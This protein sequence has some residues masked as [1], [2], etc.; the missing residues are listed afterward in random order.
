VDP[1]A[2]STLRPAAVCR[3]LLAAMEAA[4]G[5]RRSRKRDQ[6]PDALGLDVK[7][8]LLAAVVAAD[9]EPADLERWLVERTARPAAGEDAGALAAMARTVLDEWRLAHRMPAFAQW[10]DAGAPSEDAG[11]GHDRPR[12][13]LKTARLG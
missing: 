9:P 4:E 8:R 7:R 3:A 6:T 11:P 10:L 13:L 5:R 12:S 1:V 2:P